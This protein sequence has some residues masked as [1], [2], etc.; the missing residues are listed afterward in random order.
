MKAAKKNERIMRSR[1]EPNVTVECL[2]CG[3]TGLLTREALSRFSIQ[4][5]HA[6][7]GFR[8]T[9]ALPPVRQPQR[10]GYASTATSASLVTSFA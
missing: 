1:Y 4:P 6:H 5:E 9:L 7:S 8:Q 2:T 10:F 3:H